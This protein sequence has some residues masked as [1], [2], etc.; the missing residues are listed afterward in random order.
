MA[1]KLATKLVGIRL[2]TDLARELRVYAAEHDT[3][4]QAVVEQAVI[5]KI[6]N[7]GR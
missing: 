6:R 7:K 1:K 5:A 2:E 3:S 4:V